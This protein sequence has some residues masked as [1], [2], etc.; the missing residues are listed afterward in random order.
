MLERAQNLIIFFNGFYTIGFVPVI[1]PFAVIMFI[2]YRRHHQHYRN[3]LVVSILITWTMYAIYPFA[4]PRLIVGEG[5]ID[6]FAALGPDLYTS[7]DSLELYNA[8]SAMPSMHFGWTAL[9]GL[10]VYRTGHTAFKVVGMAYPT[11]MF[12]AVIVTGNHYVIDPIA[13]GLVVYASL[14]IPALITRRDEPWSARGS[15]PSG[16]RPNRRWR[17]RWD[18]NPRPLPP[19]GSALS[20]ELQARAQILPLWGMVPR[21]R[22]ELPRP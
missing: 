1:V 9:M 10:I 7:K 19:Q 14:R 6:T 13:G 4:P 17:A 16:S 12:I 11:L 15:R 22:V 18:S 8:F 21:G 5:F 2:S 3:V 20:A